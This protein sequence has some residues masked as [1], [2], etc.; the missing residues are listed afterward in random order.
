[1]TTVLN[2]ALSA[3]ALA[4]ALSGVAAVLVFVV[5]SAVH[6]DAGTGAR[7]GDLAG[8]AI[9]Y[10]VLAV[11]LGATT[12][13]GLALPV[14]AALA[15]A[16]RHLTTPASARLATALLCL[17]AVLVLGTVLSALGTAAGYLNMLIGPAA[18]VAPLVGAWRAPR[19]LGL[20]APVTEEPESFEDT[21]V[22]PPQT[23]PGRHRRRR[24]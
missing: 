5:A 8:T 14:G 13:A 6:P 16:R 24:T 23:D 22:L 2:R 11:L 1:M 4:G 9:L 21:E 7:G 19:V 15:M 20:A 18:V 12:G 3:G 10:L 17:V